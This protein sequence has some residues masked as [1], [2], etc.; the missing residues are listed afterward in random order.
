MEIIEKVKLLD[1]ITRD[2]SQIKTDS[3]RGIHQSPEIS[4]DLEENIK[5]P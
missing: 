1:T 3:M 2:I 5:I 4:R